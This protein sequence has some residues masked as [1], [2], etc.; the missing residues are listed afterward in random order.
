VSADNIKQVTRTITGTDV[1]V[2]AKLL[3]SGRLVAIPT[4]TVYGLAAD[5]NNPIAVAKIFAAKGRPNNH[6][7][8]VHIAD[9]SQLSRW[10]AEI[11]AV[12]LQLAEAFWPGPLTMI[13]RKQAHVTEA[14]TGGHDTIGLRVPSHPVALQLLAAFQDGKG[15]LAA[16]SANRFGAVSPTTAAHV[17]HELAGSI[18]Y[19]LDGGACE[20]GVEST[21][22]DLSNVVRGQPAT[23]LRPGGITREQLQQVVGILA[24]PT[25]HSPVVPG[26]LQSHYAPTAR[27]LDSGSSRRNFGLIACRR[28]HRCIIRSLTA[29]I[30]SRWQT[31][32]WSRHSSFTV[33]CATWTPPAAS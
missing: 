8:I 19:I 33:R 2:A 12:A 3:Q 31:R 9:V 32:L 18:D 6:P 7:L 1:A 30:V 13:L 26:S 10:A 29:P 25:A 28:N 22:I 11:P 16:P 27:R 20:V 23:L 21:I 17:H 5:A 15:G 24:A 14:V 4:E